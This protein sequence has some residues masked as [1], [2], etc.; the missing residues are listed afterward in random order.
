VLPLLTQVVQGRAY[1]A[2]RLVGVDLDV[3]A[4]DPVGREEPHDATGAQP[5]LLGEPVEHRLGVVPEL[6]GRLAADRVVEDVR[7]LPAHLPG[8]EERLPVDVGAQLGEVV[9]V[10]DPAALL[11][12]R[13]GV[14][15]PVDRGGVD[16]GL[17]ERR[18][19]A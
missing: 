8:V 5:P 17:L 9:V 11:R 1:G 6:A 4:V 12:H 15:L 16:A 14:A 19:R 13:R 18:H 7:E 10:E 2:P 3:L